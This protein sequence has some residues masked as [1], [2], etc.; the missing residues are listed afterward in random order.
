METL[1]HINSNR[2]DHSE[3]TKTRVADQTGNFIILGDDAIYNDDFKL[4]KHNKNTHF[5]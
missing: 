3:Y 2:D 1:L 5:R 4:K